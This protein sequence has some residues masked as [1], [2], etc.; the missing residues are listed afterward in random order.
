[1]KIRDIDAALEIFE[2]ASI[3]QSEATEQ[4]D[5]KAGNKYYDKIIKAVTFLKSENALNQLEKYLSHSSVGVKRR[6]SLRK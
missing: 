2:D 1:M 4:G 6:I 3:K 5:Y